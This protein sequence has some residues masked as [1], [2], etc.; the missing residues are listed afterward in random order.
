MNKEGHIGIVMNTNQPIKKVDY[1]RQNSIDAT[2]Q[3]G[4]N[5]NRIIN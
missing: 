2:P 1:E 5:R 3:I 4:N